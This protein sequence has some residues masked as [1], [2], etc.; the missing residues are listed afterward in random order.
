MPFSSE[1]S[2]IL[3]SPEWPPWEKKKTLPTLSLLLFTHPSCK[4]QWHRKEPQDT[5]RKDREALTRKELREISPVLF[6]SPLTVSH[7]KDVCIASQRLYSFL[8][9]GSPWVIQSNHRSPNCHGLVHDL[10]QQRN[11]LWDNWSCYEKKHLQSTT[12]VFWKMF[13]VHFSKQ[14]S[15]TLASFPM[16]TGYLHISQRTRCFK[17]WLQPPSTSH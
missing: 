4:P 14:E 12:V 9:P 11:L 5:M 7:Q 16:M 17:C 2:F 3:F 13:W 10:G 1:W 6:Y 15:V 8:D